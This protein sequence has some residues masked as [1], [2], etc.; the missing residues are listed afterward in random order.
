V[1]TVLAFG[2][3]ALGLWGEKLPRPV[4][5]TRAAGRPVMHVLRRVH[6]GHIGDYVAWLFAGVAILAGLVGIP[7]R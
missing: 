2:F 7:L 1:S 5:L 3:A 4:Q 6:S